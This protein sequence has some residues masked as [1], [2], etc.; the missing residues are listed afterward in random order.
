MRILH[1]RAAAAARLPAWRV[2][3]FHV[4]RQERKAQ[5][6]TR[7]H[8]YEVRP[9]KLAHTPR[10]LSAK[11]GSE[12]AQPLT[13]RFLIMRCKTE[14]QAL[15]ILPPQGETVKCSCFDAAR[16]GRC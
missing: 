9:G 13:N 3:V 10:V 2:V 4:P 15:W 1:A 12:A 5:Y 14:E 7:M 8:R 16:R 11:C 6:S